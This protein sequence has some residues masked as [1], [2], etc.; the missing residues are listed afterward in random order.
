M[1]RRV[2]GGVAISG[3]DFFSRQKE[4]IGWEPIALGESWVEGFSEGDDV[5]N[6]FNVWCG[7]TGQLRQAGGAR[8]DWGGRTLVRISLRTAADVMKAMGGRRSGKRRRP[9]PR[10]RRRKIVIGTAIMT[11]TGKM[12]RRMALHVND[13]GRRLRGIVA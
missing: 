1:G 10:R 7:I 12:R 2:F 13:S 5:I 9:A 6:E 11:D 4:G 3:K 8:A